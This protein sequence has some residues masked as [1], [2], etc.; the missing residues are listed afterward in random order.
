MTE[1][2]EEANLRDESTLDPFIDTSRPLTPEEKRLWS[3]FEAKNDSLPQGRSQSRDMKEKWVT[4]VTGLELGWR[5][6]YAVLLLVGLGCL[7]ASAC[8]TFVWF[9]EVS[10]LTPKEF[11]KI[12]DSGTYDMI[13][14]KEVKS[15]RQSQH[16]T[17]VG[18]ILIAAASVVTW[19]APQDVASGSTTESGQ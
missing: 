7:V 15:F 18:F 6:C 16:F 11:K 5:I 17:L 9:E 13:I 4:T 14:W 12:I 19:F 2:D 3:Y 8:S 1:R 10:S